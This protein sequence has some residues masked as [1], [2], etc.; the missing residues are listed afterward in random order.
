DSPGMAWNWMHHA[1]GLRALG[2]DVY[3][4]E[5]VE[6]RWCQDSQGR[7]C[8]FAASANRGLFQSTMERFDFLGRA[9]QVYSGGEDSFGMTLTELGGLCRGADL[10]LNISGHLKTES[11]LAG[12]R[13]RVY[14]DQDP[15]YT[16]LWR[17]EYGQ[18]L[19]FARHDAYLTV[20]L[21]IGTPHT[22]IPD[23]G[24]PWRH[25]LPPVVPDCWPVHPPAAGAR[26]TTIA[27]WGGFGDL[28][29]R[30]EWYRSK[31]EEFRRFAALPGQVGP[32]FEVALRRHSEGD[33]GV[34]LLRDHGWHVTEAARID[35]LAAYQGYIAGSR[36]EIG[37]AKNAYVRGRSGWFSDRSAH[38]LASGRP[39]LAQ[40]TGFER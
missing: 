34:R 16:Q 39:V 28:C 9:C 24:V 26:F 22:H 7:P 23:C 29:Y 40:A 1:V 5:E 33:E 27:S 4:I 35:D 3:Y 37:I 11:L 13:R 8:P 15:V 17:A 20:G 6:P 25:A 18:D 14:V 10:L 21:N 32:G 19:G 2:H 30:G 31:Y 38:Y 12:A 36:A